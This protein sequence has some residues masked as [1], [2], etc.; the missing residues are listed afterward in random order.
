MI[1]FVNKLA[2]L[3][4]FRINLCVIPIHRIC[5]IVLYCIVLFCIVLYCSILSP[6]D[7]TSIYIDLV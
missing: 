7:D 5:P 4:I 2:M 3:N 6:F 1:L